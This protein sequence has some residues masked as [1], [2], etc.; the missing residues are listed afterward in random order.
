MNSEQLQDFLKNGCVY[1]LDHDPDSI[2]IGWGEWERHTTILS[3]GRSFCSIYTPDFYMTDL[4]PWRSPKHFRVIKRS[5]FTAQFTADNLS[6]GHPNGKRFRWVEPSREIFKNQVQIIRSAFENEELVKA[7]P[8]I[9]AQALEIMTQESLINVLQAMMN[10]PASLQVHG[11]WESGSQGGLTAGLLGATPE[12]LFK[13]ERR[14]RESRLKTM[15]VAGT[16]AKTSSGDDEAL[17]LNDPKERREHQIVVDD[18][19]ECLSAHGEVS[20]GETSV[21]ELPTLFHLKTNLAVDLNPTGGARKDFESIA[22]ALHPTPA[23]G[24]A[25]RAFGFQ[26]MKRWDQVALRQRFGAPFGLR[27]KTDELDIQDCLVAIRNVQ[28]SESKPP[29]LG[30]GCGFVEESVDDH[31]WAELQLKRDSVKKVLNV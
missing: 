17:L 22:R 26:N 5:E 6:N 10:A 4:K 7:V 15:A 21:T 2:L 9:H 14:G 25:P 1:S 30:S 3:Q 24:V 20:V 12:Q 8:V 23:L 19:F 27:L 18:L 16:R 11:F 31:E 13:V 28:W 29:T